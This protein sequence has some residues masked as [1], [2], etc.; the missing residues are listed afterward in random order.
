MAEKPLNQSS[1]RRAWEDTE[2]FRNTPV[3]FW[4][5]EIVGASVLG[6]GGGYIGFLLT[7]ENA[8]P[9]QGFM[10]PAIGSVVGIIIGLLIVFLFIYAWNLYRAPYKQR[11]EAR[12]TLEKLSQK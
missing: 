4:G 3:F 5:L 6:L 12:L 9:I 8:I 7:P 2:R 11:N 10:Y 1:P